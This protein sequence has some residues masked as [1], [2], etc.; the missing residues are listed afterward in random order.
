MANYDAASINNSKRSTRIY[1]DLNLNFTKNPATKDVARL[2]D[3][4]AVKRAVRNLILTNRFE[5]PF[6]PE[7]GSSIRDLL[8]ETITPLN[9]VLLEDRIREVIGNFEPR[10]VL[11]QVLVLDELDNNRYRVTISFYVVNT[12]EPVTITE[13]LERL[14]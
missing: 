3:V 8:F 13:F 2:T 5:R 11:E 9:A 10:A 12:P 7:I 1:S 6:H 14:R 4:E